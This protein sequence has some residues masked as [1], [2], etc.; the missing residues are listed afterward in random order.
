MIDYTDG[1]VSEIA[2]PAALPALQA[3]DAGV[4]PDWAVGM[5]LRRVTMDGMIPLLPPPAPATDH[6]YVR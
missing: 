5:Q 3:V 4:A 2:L 6:L 1:T